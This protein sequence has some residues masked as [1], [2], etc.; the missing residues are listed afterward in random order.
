MAWT[1]TRSGHFSARHEE[2]DQEDVLE[3]LELLES[4]RER[5]AAVF[6]SM[7]G[8]VDV[9]VH[10][11]NTA[12]VIAQPVIAVVRRFTAPA[13][14]RYIVGWPTR[15]TIHVLSPRALEA[16]ASRVP[17]SREVELLAPAALYAQI[18]VAYNNRRMPPPIRPRSVRGLHAWGW[19]WFGAGQW[20]SGQTEFVRP[21]IARRLREGGAP[22]FPPGLRDAPLLGGALVDL[23]ARER[24]DA[25][26]VDLACE[27]PTANPRQALVRIFDG[28]PI[29]R[30]ADAWRSHLRRL[31]RP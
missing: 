8:S 20:F 3:V 15:D 1:E 2:D 9:V 10:A 21:A 25:A 7:P 11:T 16:R 17:G 18:V 19:L 23:V 22:S 14:R 6:P 4:T 12:L 27:L 26:V 31:A 28:R 29:G 5:M 30:S 24:G 13:A